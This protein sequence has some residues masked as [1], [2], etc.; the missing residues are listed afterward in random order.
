MET[1]NPP[2]RDPR[3]AK[4]IGR[5]VRD[6]FC[7]GAQRSVRV[8]A[9]QL[10]GSTPLG[11]EAVD[12]PCE[13]SAAPQPQNNH[14]TTQEETL[15][16]RTAPHPVRYTRTPG[17]CATARR[18]S[19]ASLNARA[20]RARTSEAR[21]T[22]HGC[23]QERLFSSPPPPRPSSLERHCVGQSGKAADLPCETLRSAPTTKQPQHDTG[24]DACPTHSTTSCAVYTRTPAQPRGVTHSFVTSHSNTNT[25][26]GG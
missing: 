26:R 22:P 23:T 11:W 12:L 15:A 25:A 4:E 2:P 7:M 18:D 20:A 9:V 1:D 16:P 24:R 10:Q 19:A 17:T 6:S 14:N 13:T 8:V 3:N 5:T 21:V